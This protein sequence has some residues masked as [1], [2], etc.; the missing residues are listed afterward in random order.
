MRRLLTITAVAAA[1]VL[2]ACAKTP[3]EACKDHGGVKSVVQN[4]EV[5]AP[6]EATEGAE[7]T[8]NEKDGNEYVEYEYDGSYWNQD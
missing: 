7:A 5:I 4:G 3:A 2:A 8:C 1:L 6:H